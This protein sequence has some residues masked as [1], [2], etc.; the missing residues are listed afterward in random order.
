MQP[1]SGSGFDAAVDLLRYRVAG[2][3]G[4]VLGGL[5]LIVPAVVIVLTLSLLFLA[6]APPRW[7]FRSRSRSRLGDRRRRRVRRPGGCSPRAGSARTRAARR[8]ASGGWATCCWVRAR[9]RCSGRS[10]CSSARVRCLQLAV[11]LA[12]VLAGAG[13][14]RLSS[15]GALLIAALSGSAAA[16]GI[17]ALAWEAL[18][19]G[20]LS[21]GGG[22]VIIPL[23]QADA[24][25][26]YHWMSASQFLNAV[27]LGEVPPVRWSRPLRRSAMPRTGS[28]AACWLP[29][30]PGALLPV[31]AGG[32]LTLLGAAWRTVARR[33]F[34]TAPGRRRS[35]R[36]SARPSRSRPRCRTGGSSPSSP[37]PRWRCSSPGGASCRRCSARARSA[38]CSRSA[39]WRSA[40]CGFAGF[41][42]SSSV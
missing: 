21:Y 15:H 30:S 38:S 32:R 26:T 3:V 25:H 37:A 9:R 41:S 6:Q 16:G 40:Q 23:M 13:R 27:A 39:A 28:P 1:A 22:F 31:R 10:S 12:V 18:K 2:P 42:Y 14:D 34:S 8:G 33:R 24:V 29:R 11:V 4:A 36:S 17:G 19:V 7:V 35:G 5:A 20:A